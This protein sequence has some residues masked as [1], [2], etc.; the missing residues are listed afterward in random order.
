MN[1]YLIIANDWYKERPTRERILMLLLSWAFLYALFYLFLFRQSDATYAELTSH[2]KML[3]DQEQSWNLQ[4]KALNEISRDPLYKK[5]VI[6]HQSFDTLQ[7]KYKNL[8]RAQK[9]SDWRIIAQSVLSSEKNISLVQMKDYPNLP[10]VISGNQTASNIIEQ[11]HMI[12]ITGNY[13]D[14]LSFLKR[15][16]TL[17]PNVRWNSFSY[18]VSTYPIGEAEMEFSVFYEKKP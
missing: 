16:E 15:L 14:I 5:W 13:L 8:I 1:K 12:V 18:H 10:Y 4:I 2:L 17:L 3:R 11:K 7:L 9:P 6:Q